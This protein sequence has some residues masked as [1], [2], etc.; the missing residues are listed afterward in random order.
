MRSQTLRTALVLLLLAVMS[1][2]QANPAPKSAA[3]DYSGRYSF[4]Q[5][6]ED[7][8]LDIND[9]RV[10]GYISRLGDTDT[11]RDTILNHYLAKASL[12]GDKLTF[13]SK[14]VHAVWYEFSGTIGRGPAKS[15]AEDGYYQIVGTLIEHR[16]K[17]GK[18]E[19]AR[20]REV[21]FKLFADESAP[22]T[23]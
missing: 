17:N 21:T 2:A 20:Q 13:T 16:Q 1:G 15:R 23:K 9:G 10:D 18:E 11:D 6:G 19:S 7:L 8:Q 5:E 3:P 14:P 4:L 12:T 22:T